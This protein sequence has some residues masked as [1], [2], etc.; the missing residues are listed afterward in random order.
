MVGGWFVGGMG[1]SV[2]LPCECSRV[3]R[4]ESGENIEEACFTT[5]VASF[6][7]ETFTLLERECHIMPECAH[8]AYATEFF[9][10]IA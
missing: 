5:S 6:D 10:A 7:T 8:A 2:I 4:M 3:W 1:H 9:P